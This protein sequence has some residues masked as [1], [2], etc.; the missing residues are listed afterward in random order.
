V[1]AHILGRRES[2]V[3]VREFDV[4]RERESSKQWLQ[5]LAM[6]GV[7]TYVVEREE[8]RIIPGS[9]GTIRIRM[10]GPR[11]RDVPIVVFFHGG[12][13]VLGDLDSYDNL[14]RAVAS[15]S[16]AIVVS[17]EYRTAPEHRF[18]CAV[19][20]C[21]A[22]LRWVATNR[23]E[24]GGARS[25]FVAGDSAGGN[26]AAVVAQ[27]TVN[28]RDIQLT[29]QILLYPSVASPYAGYPS[30]KHVG[31]GYSVERDVAGMRWFVEQY[32]GPGVKD[33]DVRFAPI[34]ARDLADL[35]PALLVTGELDFL[36]DEGE[37]YAHKLAA[38]R[39]AV[40]LK[41]FIGM[42]H[43]F[44]MFPGLVRAADEALVLIAG[45]IRR[46]CSDSCPGL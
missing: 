16:D 12:G 23:E 2:A 45:W 41:R 10:Y 6:I 32:L 26:L 15:T 33:D 20:D 22:A 13:W 30:Y 18:P 28:D 8:D 19:E 39:V 46:H 36:R 24:F 4:E 37:A 3:N 42:N 27:C 11:R 17:V 34:L 21:L 31:E 5:S 43:G 1:L 7:R 38:A 44:C 14:C 29:G 9:S 25:L 40:E 35:P